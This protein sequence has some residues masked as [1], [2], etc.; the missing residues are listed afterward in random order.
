[1]AKLAAERPD[2]RGVEWLMRGARP[3]PFPRSVAHLK[4]Q[5]SEKK[6]AEARQWARGGATSKKHMMPREKRPDKTVAESSKTH[7]S[8]FYQLKTGHCL[9]GQYLNWTKSGPTAQCWWCP[10]RTQTLEHCLKVCQVWREQHKTLWAEVRKETGRWKR[11]W[12][13]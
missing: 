10:C 9:S 2:A 4:W 7:T 3:A 11:R 1:L 6:W 13:I 8:R 5:I 12:K